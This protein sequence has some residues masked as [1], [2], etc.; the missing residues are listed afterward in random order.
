MPEYPQDTSRHGFLDAVV[1]FS[2]LAAAGEVWRSRASRLR[3]I[4]P[5][6]LESLAS[7]G[8]AIREDVMLAEF[9]LHRLRASEAYRSESGETELVADVRAFDAWLTIQ[10]LGEA[11]HRIHQR[12]LSLYPSVSEGLVERARIAHTCW[13]HLSEEGG[14]PVDSAALQHAADETAA[15]TIAVRDALGTRL[16]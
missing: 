5:A 7:A 10:K 12:L 3:G 13:R 14:S 6:G 1:L 4:D 11:T 8:P 15:L 9:L 16:R 2:T